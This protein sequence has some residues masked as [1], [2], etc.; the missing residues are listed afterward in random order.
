MQVPFIDS[1]SMAERPTIPPCYGRENELQ[2]IQDMLGTVAENRPFGARALIISG[3]IG[4][5][6]SRLL[7]EIRRQALT[8]H[9]QVLA[10]YL[11]E[12]GIHIPYLPFIEALRP[13]IR[14]TPTETLRSYVGLDNNQSGNAPE[15]FSLTGNPLVAALTHL[16]PELPTKLHITITPEIL[17][18][19]QE[20]FRLFDAVATLLERLSLSHPVL[21]CID[22][23][24]WA[25]SASLELMLYLT[26]RLHDSRVMLVGCTRPPNTNLYISPTDNH[27]D[28]AGEIQAEAQIQVAAMH[29]LNDLIYRELLH[30]LPLLP[31]SV[32]ASEYYLNSLLPGTIADMTQQ[33]LLARAEG[34][35]FFLEELVRS[36]TL[37]GQLVQQNGVWHIARTLAPELPATVIQA[38]EQRLQCLSSPCLQSLRVAAL[39]GRTFP[40]EIL[41]TVMHHHETQLQAALAEAEQALLVMKVPALYAEQETEIE[42]N[43]PSNAV[44]TISAVYMFGQGTVQEVLSRQLPGHVVRTLHGE[45]GAALE[46]YYGGYAIDHATELACHYV[47]S[48]KHQEALCWSILAGE[49]AARQQAHREAIGHFRHVLKLWHVGDNTQRLPDGQEMPSLAMVHQ[50]IGESWFKLGALTQAN[51]AFQHALEVGQ[52]MHLTR[53]TPLLLARINRWLADTYRLQGKYELAL[54]H[55]EATRDTL[56]AYIGSAKAAS[57]TNTIEHILYLQAQATLDLLRYRPAE[58]E[59]AL[60]QSHQLATRIGDRSSQAFALHLLGWL[61]GWG[62]RIHEAIRLQEQ[63]HD[64]YIAIGDPF[65]ATLGDQGLG[66]IYTALGD[67]EKAHLYTRRG[68]EYARRYGVRHTLGWLYWNQAMLALSEGDWSNCETQLQQARQEA[69]SMNMARLKPIIFQAQ[70]ELSFRRGHWQQAEQ[71]FQQ[72]LQAGINT[73]WY[74]SILALYGHFLAVTGHKAAARVQLEHAAA[75]PEPPGYSGCFYIPFLA[76][77]FLHVDGHARTASN[78]LERCQALR[79]FLYYGTSVDRILGEAAAFTGDWENAERAFERGLALC[80]RVHNEPEEGYIL[81]EQARTMLMSARSSKNHQSQHT[82]NIQHLCQQARSLFLRYDMQHAIQLVDT[83]QEEID[84]LEDYPRQETMPTHALKEDENI[85]NVIMKSGEYLLK[86]GLT[87]RELEVLRLVAEGHTDREV[88]DTL[89]ISYRTVNRHLGN[90]FIKLDVPGRAAAVAYAIR[91]GLVD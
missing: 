68:L 64:L 62:E 50:L 58:A 9:F 2:A 83:L 74:A 38:V 11:Y 6:K 24:Q 22:N 85:Q 46:A 89:V 14:A 37:K 28:A 55:L 20:K 59:E 86:Q 45:I 15:A 76:E 23:L 32:E 84:Q 47:L 48:N 41:V 12:T 29:L 43:L 80:R 53:T 63:A 70:A 51:Q 39:I 56:H 13:V 79:G 19:D 31:L 40:S 87:R 72:A 30:F 75:L 5:G 71:A 35:P 82:Q 16:F 54:A 44:S 25:D 17:L 52:A 60:W 67:M 36:L 77:G 49:Y 65:R 69:E 7:A 33:L 26:V 27:E 61:R 66:I 4:M 18:P 21:F 73:E 8:R 57:I 10:S 1:L 88:A 78:Y 90:I 3:E 42:P 34:N 91:H 81:Y